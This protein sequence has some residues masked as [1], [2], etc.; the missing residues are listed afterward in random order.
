MTEIQEAEKIHNYSASPFIYILIYSIM[1]KEGYS[2]WSPNPIVRQV[3]AAPGLTSFYF[4][5]SGYEQK[6]VD[7]VTSDLVFVC[8]RR[9]SFQYFYLYC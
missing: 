9:L 6:L 3:A 5:A 1:S 8:F 7:L 4:F 2:S